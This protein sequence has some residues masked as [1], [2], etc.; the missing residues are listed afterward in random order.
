MASGATIDRC[1]QPKTTEEIRDI[2][3]GMASW[4]KWTSIADSILGMNRLRAR[5]FRSVTGNVLDV[6]CGTGE[7]FAY[8]SKAESTTAVDL[9]PRM[10]EQ[11]KKRATRMGL[12]I[13]IEVGDA[14]DLRF[15]DNAF[16]YVVT[17]FSSCTFAHHKSS[18]REMERVTKPGG[19]ILMVEHG[20]SSVGWIADRQDRKIESLYEKS[21]CRNNREPGDEL[22]E[23]GL[24]VKSIRKSHLGTGN[25]IRVRVR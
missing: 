13:V 1:M 8:L 11:A 25:R 16:D 19:Q 12:D 5:Q 22:A 7:N 18:F 15:D 2:Y 10:V 21:G 9:S 23:A 14:A 24:L 3:D 17:A 6:G 20:R 4:W